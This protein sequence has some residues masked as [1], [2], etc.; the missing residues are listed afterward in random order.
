MMV[1]RAKIR[2]EHAF[3][4]S[5]DRAPHQ[6]QRIDW[7]KRVLPKLCDVMA[8]QKALGL[9]RLVFGLVLDSAQGLSRRH[10]VGRLVDASQQHRYIFEIDPGA[11]FDGRNGEFSQI[12]VRTAEIELKLNF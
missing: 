11:P 8:A 7:E 4:L 2:L 10:I 9:E 5:S 12:G 3:E 6:H 1:C